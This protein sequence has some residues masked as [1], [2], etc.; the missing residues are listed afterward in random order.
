MVREL[1]NSLGTGKEKPAKRRSELTTA[2]RYANTKR[3]L[4]HSRSHD[5][6]LFS[7]FNAAVCKL[8]PLASAFGNTS[9]EAQRE[10]PPAGEEPD[11]AYVA[12][13]R[14]LHELEFRRR[15]LNRPSKQ[16]TDH[17]T[18]SD[19]AVISPVTLLANF[20]RSAACHL[21][22]LSVSWCGS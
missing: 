2:G 9:Q 10:W 19:Q 3:A 22:F 16:G 8:S 4:L 5:M 14:D 11:G 1:G 6:I 12:A 15:E 20:G 7:L 18:A 21:S 17:F 13:A